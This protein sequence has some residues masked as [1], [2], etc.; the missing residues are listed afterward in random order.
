MRQENQGWTLKNAKEISIGMKRDVLR[1]LGMEPKEM[2]RNS[3]WR[4]RDMLRALRIDPK[5]MIGT[6]TVL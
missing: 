3:T 2:I 4:K 6:I 5:E 1:A